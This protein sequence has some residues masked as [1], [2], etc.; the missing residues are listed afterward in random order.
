VRESERE[1]KREKGETKEARLKINSE[2]INACALGGT[3]AH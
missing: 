2:N 1:R 3:P